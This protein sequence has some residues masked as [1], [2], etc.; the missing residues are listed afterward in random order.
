MSFVN[1]QRLLICFVPGLLLFLNSARAN[2]GETGSTALSGTYTVGPGGNYPTLTAAVAD[3]NSAS[4]GGAVVFSLIATSY[5]G[6]ETFPIVI[7]NNVTASATNTLTI[8]PAAGITASVSGTLD[9][10]ALIKILGSNVTI[11]GSANGTVSRDLT[12]I[13]YGSS[14]GRTVLIGSIS[15]TPTINTALKNCIILAGDNSSNA[16]ILSDG[17]TINAPGYF[18]NITIGNNQ[19]GNAY[20]GIY[21][22]AVVATGNGSG[23]L[24][25]SNDLSII[26]G[27]AILFIGIFVQGFDGATVQYNTVGNFVGTD[28]NTDAGIYIGTGSK[29]TVVL[30]NTIKNLNYTGNAGYGA[31]GIYINTNVSNA[32]ILVAGNMVANITGDGDDYTN[33]AVTLNNPVGILL[34]GP[35][36][37]IHIYH[38][39]VFLGGV[40]GYT[41]TLNKV[42]AVSSCIRIYGSGSADVRNNILVNN[43][44]LSGTLGYGAIGIQLSFT[45]TQFTALNFNDYSINPTGS[46]VSAFGLIATTAQTTLAS[47]K[48]ATGKDVASLNVV[49]VFF[50]PTNLHLVSGLNTLLS[51]VAAP[52]AGFTENDIDNETRNPIACEVGCDEIIAAN[53]AFWVGKISSNWATPSNWEAN[54]IPG[55]TSDVTISGGYGFLPTLTTTQAV[56]NLLI[57]NPATPVLTLNGGTLQVYGAIS[58]SSGNIDGTNG[59]LAMNGSAP[60]NIPAGIFV[61]NNLNSF[62]IGNSDATTGVSLNGALDIY[63]SVSFSATGLKLTTNDYLSFKSTAAETAWL[64]DVTGKTISGNVVVERYIPTG[65]PGPAT[66]GKSWQ[67]LAIPVSGMQTVNAAWQESAASP[68]ANPVSGYGTQITGEMAGA[69]G[70]GFDVYTPSGASMKVY[71]ASTGSYIG[72]ANTN[73]LSIANQKGYM[74]FVRGDRSITAYNQ[75]AVATILRTK[76]KLFTTGADLPPASN[77][78]VNK[79]ES[80]GNPYASAIDFT[81]LTRT[82]GVDNTYYTW[83]PL[84]AGIGYGGYQTISAVTGWVP[85]PGGTINYPT[86]VAVSSIQSGQAFLVHATAAAG[87][88]SFTEA[89]K[90]AGSKINF[91]AGDQTGGQF[92]KATLYASEDTAAGIADGNILAFDAGYSN[93]YDG[94]DALK[95]VNSTANFGILSNN[96]LLA[97]E[98]RAPLT[99]NDTVFYSLGN[100]RKQSYR[101]RFAPVNIQTPGLTAYFEDGFLHTSTLLELDVN[102]DVIF[103][104]TDDA[105]SYASDRFYIVFRLTQILPVTFTSISAIRNGEKRIALEWKTANET[106]IETYEI[107]RSEDGRSFSKLGLAAPKANN[108][109]NVSYNY[110]DESPLPSDN[111]YSIRAISLSGLVQYSAVVKV[112]RKNAAHSISVYPNPVVDKKMSV[113]FINQ[114]AGEYSVKLVNVV[115]Q[116]IYIDKAEVNNNSFIKIISLGTSLAA[117][118]YQLVV[119][120][121]NGAK[122]VEQVVIR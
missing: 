72:I 36:T 110:M 63:K 75:A 89:A 74:V 61:N 120:G 35:Q 6:S 92:F 58:C 40:S 8:S 27:N 95:F 38:N 5:S 102:S 115:G 53:T 73:S 56:K 76:G 62:L 88:L 28:A 71:N 16:V 4:L 87:T 9:N 96:K 13:N 109:R 12:L 49:P 42:N 57:T 14:L 67:L 82:G 39:S 113:S 34:I 79:F 84:L 85:S 114:P 69:M 22:N 29:N 55:A 3:Y 59:T 30:N 25:Q 24:I 97:V 2:T 122:C 45:N 66:H 70:L 119:T 21:C 7:N 106:G 44:G 23:L 15:L 17:T 101:L 104:V 78:Q 11:D 65:I 18:N 108:G 60:Q 64:G 103:R 48:M 20:Y 105:G 33:S 50:S 46:A 111:F 80:V 112:A 100:L 90:V 41:N 98:A 68:N 10:N 81:A 86:G 118:N 43:L 1:W 117:G 94:N 77:V 107:G 116:V 93:A 26:G 54:V 37:G 47:W 91:R 31:C 99:N 83:D 51:N 32:G 19:I 52:I 121:E